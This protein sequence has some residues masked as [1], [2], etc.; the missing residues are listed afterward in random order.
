MSVSVCPLL[1]HHQ[2]RSRRLIRPWCFGN[3]VGCLFRPAPGF[4]THT[5]TVLI[6]PLWLLEVTKQNGRIRKKGIKKS[7][8][9]K[10]LTQIR[11]IPYNV[12]MSNITSHFRQND[13][14]IAQVCVSIWRSMPKK[15]LKILFFHLIF[16]WLRLIR[17]LSWTR[18]GMMDNNSTDRL[19]QVSILTF[20]LQNLNL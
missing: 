7:S 5:V 20:L 2:L 13:S 11:V 10:W 16:D 9:K 15:N 14:K 1:F 19:R 3:T 18:S 4:I 12:S 6:N 8:R 17:A